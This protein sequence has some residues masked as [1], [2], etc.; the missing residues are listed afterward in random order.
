MMR[1]GEQLLCAP[2]SYRPQ[3]AERLRRR[4]CQIEARNGRPPTPGN[5]FQADA[6]DHPC[7]LVVRKLRIEAC[8]ACCNPLPRRPQPGE[9]TPQRRSGQRVQSRAQQS[10][11]LLLFNP[12]AIPQLGSR[13]TPGDT[14]VAVD[15]TGGRISDHSLRSRAVRP[16]H[17]ESVCAFSVGSGKGEP[18]WQPARTQRYE[19]RPEPHPRRRPALLVVAS[20]RCPCCMVPVAGRDRLQQVLVAAPRRHHTD[21]HPSQDPGQGE[22]SGF[23][24]APRACP[25]PWCQQCV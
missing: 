3:Y 6:F 24:C 23:R 7:T 17:R 2:V 12:V 19:P 18:S 21:R 11:E 22:V 20:Q 9:C 4:E 13:R 25:H 16:A 15:G 5:L 14:W 10:R 8:N 1:G